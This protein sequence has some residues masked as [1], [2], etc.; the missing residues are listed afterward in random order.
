MMRA[1]VRLAAFAAL[2]WR[3]EHGAEPRVRRDVS[4]YPETR[5][6]RS[7]RVPETGQHQPFSGGLRPRGPSVRT[8][9][10]LR[11]SSAPCGGMNLT[12]VQVRAELGIDVAHHFPND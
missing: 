8:P 5:W 7:S 2:P 11:S 3:P 12:V 10:A 1:A 6:E 9:C 4:A